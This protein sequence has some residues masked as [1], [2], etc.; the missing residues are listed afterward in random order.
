MKRLL[1]VVNDAGFFLSHRARLAAAARDNGYEVHVATP[2]GSLSPRIVAEGFVY[3]PIPMARSGMH[4]LQ[5]LR[6]ISALVRLYRQLAPD[7]VHHITIKPVLYGGIAARWAGM[8]ASVSTITG[9]GHVFSDPALASRVIRTMVKAGYRLI[10]LHPNTAVIFQNAEDY[11]TFTDAGTVRLS[12]AVIIRGS[13]VDVAEF[14]P[15]DEQVRE[16]PLVICACRM[17]KSKGVPEFVAAAQQLRAKGV[18]ARF[19]LVGDSDPDNPASISQSVLQ[20]WN[21]AGAVEWWGQRNDMSD[22]IAGANLVCL[23]SYSE[24]VPKALIEAAA[25]GRAIVATDIPG[26]REIVRHEDNGLLVPPRDVP[27]LA[28]AIERLLND[29]P[30]RARMGARGREIAVA[31]FSLDRVIRETLDVYARLLR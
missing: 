5:E 17:L 4:P 14:F 22:V 26:C 19:I 30:M 2:A 8:P 13:G 10:F 31:E 1:Y 9:M 25:C 21:S 27:A 16:P 28:A 6:S 15:I 12:D 23:P 20:G 24:G 11:K 18:R 29:A 7:L 3:H